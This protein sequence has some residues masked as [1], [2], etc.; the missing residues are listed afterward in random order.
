MLD[1]HPSPSLEL[2]QHACVLYQ[3][4]DTS[5]LLDPWLTDNF[6]NGVFHAFP[7]V[8]P[9][10]MNRLRQVSAIH[11]SHLHSDHFCSTS[12]EM[13]DKNT[14]IIIAQ[15]VDRLFFESVKKLG[16][17]NI[18]EV[19]PGPTGVQ[20]K[21]IRL[22][23]FAAK[24]HY[25]FDSSLIITAEDRSYLFDNDAH[26]S[27]DHY[28]LLGQYF[29]KFEGIFVGYTNISPFPT[30]YDFSNCKNVLSPNLNNDILEFAKKCSLKRIQMICEHLKPRWVAP[31][32][33]GLRF[34]HKNLFHN[35]KMFFS[36]DDIFH[37]TFDMTEVIYIHP[38]QKISS[39][40]DIDDLNI[41]HYHNCL[42]SVEPLSDRN[43]VN[44]QPPLSSSELNRFEEIYI[45]MLNE[46]SKNWLIPMKIIIKIKNNDIVDHLFCLIVNEKIVSRADD[47]D[48][49]DLEIIYDGG[50][51]KHLLR[52]RWSFPQVHFSYQWKANVQSIIPGQMGIPLWGKHRR[53]I[54][55]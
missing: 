26:F 21:D 25:P 11:I 29:K 32:A 52:D 42:E 1:Q 19:T 36:L 23:V 13:F 55:N 27:E 33:A 4:K 46:E 17:K 53:T 44:T 37:L 8:Q 41:D 20:F 38:G 28:F 43:S 3:Y 34:K 7:S 40:T 48:N 9:I 51:I 6:N 47:I 24:T 15:H 50:P 31:Y 30:C 45:Q 54:L 10:D 35:N 18:I 14:P 39:E 12:L 5:V 22:N 16:F 49:Y 2:I